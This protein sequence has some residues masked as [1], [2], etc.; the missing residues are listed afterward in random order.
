MNAYALIFTCILIL[1]NFIYGQIV[2]KRKIER[3][4]NLGIKITQLKLS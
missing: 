3:Q 1:G 4:V 2:M